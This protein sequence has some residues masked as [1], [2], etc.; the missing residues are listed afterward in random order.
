MQ[1]TLYTI[2]I[3]TA[4]AMVA[5]CGGN[6]NL[7]QV[8]GIV[9]FNGDPVEGATVSFIPASPDGILAVGT[10]DAEGRYVL[11]APVQDAGVSRGALQGT[12]NVTIRKTEVTPHP[13]SVLYQQGEITYNELMNRGGGGQSTIREVLPVRFNDVQRSGL[14]AEVVAQTQNV[15]DFALVD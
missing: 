10:T 4:F 12:Y 2:T 5:G 3:L 8:T 13:D 11:A 14:Q 9:T 7:G 6:P 15:F 1:K